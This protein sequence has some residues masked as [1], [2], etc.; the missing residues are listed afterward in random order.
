MSRNKSIY[1]LLCNKSIIVNL[2]KLHFL[3]FHFSFQTNKRVFHSPTFPSLQPNIHEEKLNIFYLPTNFSSSY[4]STLPT[5][6]T[7]NFFSFLFVVKRERDKRQRERRALVS[8][9]HAKMR[10]YWLMVHPTLQLT[11]IL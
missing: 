1:Y 11:P 7:W 4:F 3:F 10:C 5:K 9:H 2:Y 8:C 6:R